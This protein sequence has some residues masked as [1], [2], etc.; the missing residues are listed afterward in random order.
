MVNWVQVK[1]KYLLSRLAKN[2]GL[3]QHA[4]AV[5][6][7]TVINFW[8]PKHKAPAKK[9]KKATTTT[10][11][12][13]VEKDQYRGEETGKPAVVLV[14]GFAGDGMMTW[15]FQVGSL[16]KRYD[17][18][19]PDLVHFGG[20]T[21]PSPDRSVGFQAACVAAALERLGVERCAVV[22][23]S[24][25][26]LV[27]FQMA[28]ACPG[29]VRSVV[30]S[31]ADVAY[32]GAMNDALLA[33]LGGAARKITELML[34]ESVAGV[35]RLFSAALH[36]RMWM[37]SCLL[38]D[39]LKVMYSNRK[40]RTEMPNA[41]V[42]K[43]TQVLTPAFQQGILLLWGESDN[44]F[45]IESAKRLKEELGEKVTLRSIRK[46][47]HLAQLERPFV[48]NRCLKEFLARVNAI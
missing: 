26:G 34:P 21:S 22:G 8:L 18:Y 37:P 42:V 23:F 19:V 35:S 10:P 32:T 14:H 20:S 39:F 36:M 12:P 28:A 2:A 11:V 3:R 24:Y 16:R 43:D 7:G 5:D 29:L 27:A 38:S 48:Y 33:R 30:V 17:V 31:G 6:A 25:G 44:F 9:K 4:V 46:A 1:R 47:G 15:A 45:P 13:T 40:E 41:M